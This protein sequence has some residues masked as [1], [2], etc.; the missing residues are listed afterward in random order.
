MHQLTTKQNNKCSGWY[1]E[2]EIQ[3]MA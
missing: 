2:Q 1:S 3:R